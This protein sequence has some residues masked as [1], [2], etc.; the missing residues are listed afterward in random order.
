MVDRNTRPDEFFDLN[1]P[2][3]EAISRSIAGMLRRIE[4]AQQAFAVADNP[5]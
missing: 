3:R 1:R 2:D 4:F 5:R